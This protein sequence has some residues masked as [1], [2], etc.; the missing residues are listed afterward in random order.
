MVN[1]PDAGT[2][3]FERSPWRIEPWIRNIFDKDIK[4]YQIYMEFY[5]VERV[6]LLSL[7][8]KKKHA[9]NMVFIVLILPRVSMMSLNKYQ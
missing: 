8:E 9:S 4:F 1:I 5:F 2:V 7:L 6:F 3:C